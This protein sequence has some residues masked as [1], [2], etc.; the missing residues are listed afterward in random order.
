MVKR[1]HHA[2]LGTPD[3]VHHMGK[4]WGTLPG[5][6]TTLLQTGRGEHEH[7]ENQVGPVPANGHQQG[8]DLG[9]GAAPAMDNPV[10]G[11]NHREKG[12]KKFS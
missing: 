12:G 11:G 6:L 9:G 10:P 7:P 4:G 1:H 8:G 2:T 3:E 5:Q